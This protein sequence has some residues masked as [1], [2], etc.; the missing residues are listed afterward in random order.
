VLDQTKLLLD[1]KEEE[2]KEQ[3]SALFDLNYKRAL[4]ELKE[5]KLIIKGL[6]FVLL[7]MLILGILGTKFA[8]V[9]SI[10]P[11]HESQICLCNFLQDNS[12]LRFKTL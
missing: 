4:L 12:D 3:T 7:P 10:I 1:I 2:K 11:A 5:T 8:E 6:L 9:Y